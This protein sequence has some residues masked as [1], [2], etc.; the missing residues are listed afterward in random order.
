MI[1]VHRERCTGCGLCIEACPADAIH[2]VEDTAGRYAVVDAQACRA[3]EA[4]VEAC[5]VGA[6]TSTTEPVIEGEVIQ[7]KTEPA[8]V[9][10]LPAQVR[11]AQPLPRAL[12][13]MGAALA[14]AGREILPRV[15]DV[16]LDA[17]DRR[18]RTP[19]SASGDVTP[20]QSTGQPTASLPRG[21]GGRRRRR[22]RGS[23]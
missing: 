17:W 22:R 14:F 3:C 7:V 10:G 16:L 1:T 23:S 4:C 20:R 15:A 11:P 19:A 18:A 12:S 6:I 2:L 8:P 9:G 21:G 13:W 5:P